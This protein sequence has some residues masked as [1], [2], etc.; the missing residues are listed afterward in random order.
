MRTTALTKYLCSCSV[1]SDSTVL[2]TMHR[3]RDFMQGI[4]LDLEKTAETGSPTAH[5]YSHSVPQE[6][7]N[8][9]LLNLL[10]PL[11]S[12]FPRRLKKKLLQRSRD[13]Q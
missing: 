13:Y 6:F 7:E 3:A 5:N 2:Q 11:L 8:V 12:T 1:E 9:Q 4:P 10:H